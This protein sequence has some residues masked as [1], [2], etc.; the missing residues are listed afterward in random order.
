[1]Q[2][3]RLL[4]TLKLAASA[5]AVT[6][7]F[8]LIDLKSFVSALVSAK[9]TFLISA[10]LISLIM[11]AINAL[12]IKLLLPGSLIPFRYILFTNFAAM[13]LRLTVPTDL[14]AELGRG[15]F[16]SKKTDSAATAFSAIAL[17]RYFGLFSQVVVFTAAAL[18]FGIAKGG[19]AVWTRL[20]IAALM[21]CLLLAGF[22]GALSLLPAIKRSKKRG[23]VKLTSALARFSDYAH[24]LRSMPL[25][26]AWVVLIS[27]VFHCLTLFMI[28]ITSAAYHVSLG[29]HEAAAISLSS[30]VSFVMP[31]TVGGLGVIEGIY[32][33]L[34]VLF[35]LQKEIGLAVSLTMRV[36]ALILALPGALFFIFGERLFLGMQRRGGQQ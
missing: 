3:K 11:P 26:V 20:G 9:P 33:A 19:G 28:M 12:K 10:F 35:A 31:F 7:L 18:I 14:G 8:Y 6:L 15:Y 25:R 27:L 5:I 1:M 23:L 2:K 16:L 21:G 36:M 22:I 29:F 17:D 32:T 30:T 24:R 34:Y 4:F 13:F